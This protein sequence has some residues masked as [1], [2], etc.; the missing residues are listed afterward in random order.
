M[1]KN[2]FLTLCQENKVSPL[3]VLQDREVL[4]ILSKRVDSR[5]ES[6]LQRL[7]LAEYIQKTFNH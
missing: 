4:K 6:D 1:T 5:Q 3:V 2:D 7:E